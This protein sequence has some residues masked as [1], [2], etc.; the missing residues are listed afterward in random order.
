MTVDDKKDTLTVS[1]KAAVLVAKLTATTI[2][3]LGLGL[4]SNLPGRI[5]RKLSPSVLSHLS[6]Q[7]ARGVLAVTGTNGKSTTSGILSS[8][9]RMA[10]FT[11]A[12]NRQ[13]AN[14]VTGITASLVES[15]DW[16]DGIK[17]DL[18]L[19]EIDEAALPVVAKEVKIG[20][21]LV[22]NL[23]RDQLDRFGELD[24]TARLISN[25]IMI[26]HSQ[27]ILNADDPNVSQLVPDTSRLFYGIETLK[28]VAVTSKNMELAYCSKCNAEVSYHQIFYGQL[29]HW[30]CAQ[31]SNTR[32]VPHIVAR[33]VEVFGTSS[34]FKLGIGHTEEDCVIP[35]PGLFNVYNALAAAAAAH[36]LGV[37][38]QAIRSGL[39]EYSTLFGRS[40]KLIIEGKSVIVQLI[41][42]PAGATQA[43]SSCV[44][45]KKA[46]LLIAINDNLADGRDVSWLWDAD[47]ELLAASGL[48]G[49]VTVSGL[50]AEDM[51]VRMKYAGYPEAKITC[52]PKLA[53]ALRHCLNELKDDETLWL[54]PTYTNLLDLQKLLKSMGVSMSCT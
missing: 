27:A 24:T 42:N 49:E 43:I 53:S 47:F 22:T 13:G 29:G 17:S 14:L 7:T 31:C 41:K 19:F 45:D 38:N 21:V 51:A 36:Q 2:R 25:G 35:L 11:F 44:L 4:G 16:L 5:A 15:A 46:R 52:I 30:Y 9:L 6:A 20:V 54:M 34:R 10:G 12:H 48:T 8:I 33:D 3:R 26:N 23:F 32:P 50:R 18:C 40:E 39:K 1:D 37:S 28:D